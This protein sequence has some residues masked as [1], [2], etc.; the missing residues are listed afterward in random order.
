MRVAIR[1]LM[2]ASLAIT[3]AALSREPGRDNLFTLIGAILVATALPYVLATAVMRRVPGRW[4]TAIGLVTCLWGGVDIAWRV[5]AFFY[6]TLASGGGMAVWLPIYG[7]AAIAF[8]A[9][10]AHTFLTAFANK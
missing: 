3:F 4:P 1:I 2:V 10:I 7:A 9:V 6:P 8:F 5:Q